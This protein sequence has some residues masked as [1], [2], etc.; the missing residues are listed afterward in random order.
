MHNMQDQLAR[1]E[2]KSVTQCSQGYQVG[3]TTKEEY[4][5]YTRPHMHQAEAPG[6]KVHTQARS[7]CFA[8]HQRPYSI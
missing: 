6:E 4:H 8:M 3:Y 7:G 5:N 2:T 1:R